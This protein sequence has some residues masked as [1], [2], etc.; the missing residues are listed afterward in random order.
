LDRANTRRRAIVKRYNS[1]F[2]NIDWVDTPVEKKYAKSAN[3]NYVIKI[4]NGKRD[5]LVSYLA[6]NGIATSVHYIP[7]HLYN[8]YKPFY[9]KL[10]IAENV[11]KKLIT[12]PLYPDLRNE[13]VDFIIDKVM[14]FE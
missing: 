7:N 10:P 2:T 8:I 12:L 6:D 14:K 1:A 11:W 4:L 9:R 5:E 13:E 3:H